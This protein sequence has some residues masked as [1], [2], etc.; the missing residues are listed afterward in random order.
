MIK[1]NGKAEKAASRLPRKS[2]QVEKETM[3]RRKISN[4]RAGTFF[5]RGILHPQGGGASTLSF[6]VREVPWIFAAGLS[7]IQQVPNILSGLWNIPHV[8][9]L[10]KAKTLQSRYVTD[11]AR[12]V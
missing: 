5:I 1:R 10:G 9:D 2:C 7:S 8:S 6:H 3:T 4:R 11:M 12:L